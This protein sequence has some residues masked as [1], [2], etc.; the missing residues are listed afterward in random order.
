MKKLL[1]LLLAA[2]MLVSAIPASLAED[3]GQNELTGKIIDAATEFVPDLTG[4]DFYVYGDDTVWPA[5]VADALPASFDLRDR[6]V[7]PEVRNQGNWGSCWGFAAIG[8]CEIS[9]LSSMGLTVEQ[10]AEKKGFDMDLSERHLAWFANNHMPLLSDY[11]EGEY[12]YF[13]SVAGEG[14]WHT[15]DDLTPSAAKYNSGGNLAYASSV[16]ANGMGPVHE[17]VYPY[18]ANDGT[19]SIGADWTLPEEDRFAMGAEL[20]NARILPSPS[21][22]DENGE[23]YYLEA[24]TEAIKQE[25]MAGRGVSIT[26]HA[27]MSMSPD[28]SR[29]TYYDLAY[30]N[31]LS[32]E[33]ADIYARWVSKMLDLDEMTQEQKRWAMMGWAVLGGTSL[34]SLTDEVLDELVETNFLAESIRRGYQVETDEAA[35]TENAAAVEEYDLDTPEGRAAKV[36]ANLLAKGVPEEYAEISGRIYAGLLKK[37]DMTQED[38]RAFM[39][40][41]CVSGGMSPAE[42]TD[43]MLDQNIELLFDTLYE[44]AINAFEAT[45][46]KQAA[47]LLGVDRNELI[48]FMKKCSEAKQENYYNLE[49]Y[50]QCVDNAY[51]MAD[52]A[53]VIVGWDDNYAVENFPADHQPPAP[54]AW[55]VRNSW[56]SAYGDEGYFYLSYYDQS[57]QSAETFEFATDGNLTAGLQ[58]YA[59]DMMQATGVS[60]VHMEEPVY[61]AN[62]FGLTYDAVLSD[63][64]VMTAD[65]NAQVTVGV[66]LLDST[67]D[68]PTDGILLDTVT[69]TFDY[70][71]YHRMSLSKGFEIPAGSYISVVQLQ[72]VNTTEGERYAVPFAMAMSQE[73][74]IVVYTMQTNTAEGSFTWMEGHIGENES[75]VYAGGDWLDWKNVID[76]VQTT[77]QVAALATFDNLSMKLYLYTDDGMRG[78]HQFG[79]P[80]AY[81][82]G[83]AE[84]C[85]DCGY[86]IVNID[87]K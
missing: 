57:I 12:P 79:D 78:I 60:S 8:A 30:R 47:E 13:E 87:Q 34:D 84:I 50:A 45:Y 1:S 24:G 62:A 4:V 71:G 31:G 46:A 51:A 14:I 17:S 65:L 27:E 63:V 83:T 68:S 58:I 6:G 38:K 39:F 49:T 2:A 77:D 41:V 85:R 32:E 40:A 73:A 44:Q 42:L 16:F 7:V 9:I 3:D 35:E 33:A 86:T 74:A 36:K 5:S 11:P 43:E 69:E 64:S 22:R 18:Q 66:Y 19:L 15:V 29:E 54:G 53:V 26:Y 80:V 59:Y 48:E 56:G 72:K 82:G 67:A 25:L 61:L 52:H 21:Q 23:Y 75:W 81:P 28:A 37:E 10:Y 70:A 20:K 55:I 76:V